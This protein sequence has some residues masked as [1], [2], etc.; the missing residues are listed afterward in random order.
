MRRRQGTGEVG[1][2]AEEGGGGVREGDNV[3]HCSLV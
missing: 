2:G 1:E 3:V